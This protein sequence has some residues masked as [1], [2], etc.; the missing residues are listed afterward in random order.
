MNSAYIG[1]LMELAENDANVIHLLADSG[2]GYD[3]MFKRCFPQQMYN[4]GIAEEN[5]VSAA[6]GMAMTGKIPFAFTAGAFL[7]YRS[8]E[9]IRD[10]ICFQNLN[11]KIIGM[12]SGL[13]WSSL[14][15]THHT[16]EDIAILR[17][18]PNLMIL[19]PATPNQVK[20]CVRMAYEHFGPVY[21][22][23]EM[24][25][26]QEYFSDD[27]VIKN[28]GFDVIDINDGSDCIVFVTGSILHEVMN[29][30]KILEANGVSAKI[31]NMVQLKPLDVVDIIKIAENFKRIFTV[32]EHNI[33]GGLGGI[34][35]EIVAY[36][37]LNKKIIPIGLKDRFAVGYGTHEAVRKKN[38]LSDQ[39]I[40]KTIQEAM[41]LE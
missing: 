20:A 33:I 12:G 40:A 13:S 31:V 17:A 41:S 26:E 18:L 6:A 38:N 16:T 5:M 9:F 8:L 1:A 4:F 23:I 27:C 11:V 28:C 2:T 36:N 14:G 29:A 10:D 34:L 19:S 24:N 7:A 37:G 21:I 25:H 15:P 32:E 35:A 30:A 22:K 39:Q 3:E